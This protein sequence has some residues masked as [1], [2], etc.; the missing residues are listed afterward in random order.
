MA[1]LII[2]WYTTKNESWKIES[3]TVMIRHYFKPNRRLFLRKTDEKNTN[4]F[5]KLTILR[6]SNQKNVSTEN[7][8]TVHFGQSETSA[9]KT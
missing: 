1:K 9:K 5:N 8:E 3:K 4:K 2:T 6:S 7:L